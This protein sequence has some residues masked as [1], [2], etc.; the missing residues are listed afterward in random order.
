MANIDSAAVLCRVWRTMNALGVALAR[1]AAALHDPEV[2]LGFLL[3]SV[4]RSTIA[5]TAIL[6][7]GKVGSLSEMRC[8]SSS[9]GSLYAALLTA[10]PCIA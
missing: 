7:T 6:S 5:N 4:A 8:W 2:T 3:T 1:S 10:R 9:F